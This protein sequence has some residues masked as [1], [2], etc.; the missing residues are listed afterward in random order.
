MNINVFEKCMFFNIFGSAWSLGPYPFWLK[1]V[2][3]VWA[4]IYGKKTCFL[5]FDLSSIHWRVALS[6]P[7]PSGLK[8]VQRSLDVYDV[9][10]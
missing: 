5:N 10:F 3:K 7:E 1:P 2:L 6:L 8:V 9:A 4:V